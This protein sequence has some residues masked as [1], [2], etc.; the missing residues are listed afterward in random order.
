MCFGLMFGGLVP[1]NFGLGC[2]IVISMFELVLSAVWAVWIDLGLK[3]Q[4]INIF[5]S[6]GCIT[7]VTGA[8]R[9]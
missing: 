8:S 6:R 4:K 7:V 5:G 2:K 3:A 1:L 9:S